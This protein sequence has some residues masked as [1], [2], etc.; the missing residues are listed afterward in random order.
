MTLSIFRM[1]IIL[2]FICGNLFG[3]E[4]SYD[5]HIQQY[6][7]TW[8]SL[9]PRYAKI[10]YAGS[11]GMFSVGPGWNYGHNHWET[12]LLFGFV[13]RYSDQ[14]AMATFTL[15]QNYLP[16]SISINKHFSFDPLATGLYLNTLLD[17]DFWVKQPE[18]YPKNYYTF[19]TRIRAH[20]F[21]GQRFTFLL[22][23]EKSW[24]KSLSIFYELSTCDMYL[25]SALGNRYLKPKDYLSLSFG[26]KMQIL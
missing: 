12:D 1:E 21:I 24:H 14:H 3:Q 17:K 10:Q 7:S 13:P 8:N 18:R 2:L 22:P 5:K 23:K 6:T 25:I 16:W 26:L 19:S 9:I 4:I 20:I 11:M 15:K